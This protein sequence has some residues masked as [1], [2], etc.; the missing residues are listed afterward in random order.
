VSRVL[1]VVVG[2]L[3]VLGGIAGLAVLFNSR[4]GAQVTARAGG[5]G[6]LEPD[7]GSRHGAGVDTSTAA[8]PNA[9]GTHRPA[10]VSADARE[11]TRDQLLHALELG[12]VVM[13]YPGARPPDGLRRLQE[14]VAG[15]F[16]P[17][18]AAAG[19][20]VILARVPGIPGVQGL[21]WRRHLRVRDAGDPALKSFAE[22]WLGRGVAGTR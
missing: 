11:L 14:A 21:A 22:A 16:D 17:E 13:A 19:Q 18:L 6:E 15:P 10:L 1:A 3:V 8:G 20:A 5:P 9:S 2:V 12:D 4:D 7:L